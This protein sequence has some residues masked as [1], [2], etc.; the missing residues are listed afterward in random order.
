MM[1]SNR[2]PL[3]RPYNPLI[4]DPLDQPTPA[5][6]SNPDLDFDFDDIGERRIRHRS[7]DLE[8]FI[9]SDDEDTPT[10]PLPNTSTLSTSPQAEAL[11]E[12]GLDEA[13]CRLREGLGIKATSLTDVGPSQQAMA[14]TTPTA[15]YTRVQ[16]LHLYYYLS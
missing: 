14:P 16:S 5:I 6:P 1:E 8:V 9:I 4:T 2:W 10:L 11:E 13:G 7:E 15:H 12:A 3:D